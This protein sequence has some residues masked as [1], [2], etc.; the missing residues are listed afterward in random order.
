MTEPLLRQPPIVRSRTP[1][2]RRRTLHALGLAVDVPG[3]PVHAFG[4]AGD[5]LGRAVHAPGHA[6]DAVFFASFP[7]SNWEC[8]FPEAVLRL[9]WRRGRCAPCGRRGTRRH[10]RSAASRNWAFPS[11]TWER[12]GQAPGVRSEP[13]HEREALRT[14]V[15]ALRRGCK[16]L[17][18]RGKVR[19]DAGHLSPPC[20]RS[21][22]FP[23]SPACRGQWSSRSAFSMACISG[24]AR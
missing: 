2:V 15:S 22:P 21:A 16:V 1:H 3:Q 12:E 23:I 18:I 4:R 24:I 7:S 17:A 14:G 13:P 9:A 19:H 20:L 10:R 6:G 8:L 11:G 5:A